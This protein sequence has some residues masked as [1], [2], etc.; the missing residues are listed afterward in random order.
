MPG[1]ALLF[2]F[3]GTLDADG[4]AWRDRFYALYKRRGLGGSPEAFTRAFHASDDSLPSRFRL[5]GLELEETLLL[6]TQG[7][8]EALAPERM[9]EAPAIAA[10]FTAESRR[11]FSRNR[12]VLER[13][14]RSWRLG[15]VSNFYGNLD[16]ILNGE[17]LSGL[18]GAVADSGVVGC[19][20]P[21]SRIF[22]DAL[23]R[24]GASPQ[25]SW[26][27]GDSLER[28]MRGAEAL[29]LRHAWLRGRRPAENACCGEARVLDSLA[30][31]E[32]ALAE[33]EGAKR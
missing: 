23:A 19:S 22:L 5:R 29:G 27:V 33:A 11:S 15:I 8:L 26:M 25:E 6:Q 10:E 17:G 30:E 1:R 20:K 9:D 4:V 3:G 21:E 7:V 2:D 24:L 32:G 12:P 13:L 16:S 18:F 31:L 28:D 14:G